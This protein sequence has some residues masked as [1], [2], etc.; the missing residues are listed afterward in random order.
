MT[1]WIDRPRR[2]VPSLC[3]LSWIWIICGSLS[4]P[5]AEAIPWRSDLH[6]SEVEARDRGRLLWIQFT[7]SW[8][9]NCVRLERE[10]FAHPQVIGHARNS[11]VPVKILSEEREDLVERFGLTGIPATILV[12]PSGEVVARHEGYVDTPTFHAFLEKALAQ[13]GRSSHPAPSVLPRTPA[14]VPPRTA[15]DRAAVAPPLALAGYCPVSIVTGHRLVPGH[16]ALTLVHNGQVFRFADDRSRGM[17]LKQPEMFIPAN[18]GRCPVTQVERGEIRPGV[19]R[20]CVL[21]RDHLY[22]CADEEGRSRFL[23]NPERYAHVA[24]AERQFCPHCWG[25]EDALAL[26]AAGSSL[27][28]TGWRSR[29]IDAV[30]LETRRPGSEA[31]R[32]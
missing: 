6:T 24:V 26:G 9:P 13:V 31:L 17:F 20:W 29:P 27:V 8:C 7:G 21:F 23:K 14:T 32:R 28:P 11:F 4:A 30:S 12:K 5:G 16:P 19:P 10:A 18:G 22:L 3:L 1:R 25:R 2:A 15:N